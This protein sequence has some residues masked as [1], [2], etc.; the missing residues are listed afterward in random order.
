[1]NSNTPK[2]KTLLH[3][4]FE[5]NRISLNKRGREIP[6]P[7]WGHTMTLIDNDLYVFGGYTSS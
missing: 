4:A 5:W 3:H 6:S 7:R 1:M 2:N